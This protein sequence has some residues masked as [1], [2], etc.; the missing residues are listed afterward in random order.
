MRISVV[1]VCS[2]SQASIADTL[3]SVRLQTHPSVK[4][5][6]IDGASS[7]GTMEIVR[8]LQGANVRILSEEDNGSQRQGIERQFLGMTIVVGHQQ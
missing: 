2:N 3:L 6:I 7:D 4:H 5:M 1:T 8:N